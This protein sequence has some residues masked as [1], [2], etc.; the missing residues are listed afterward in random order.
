VGGDRDTLSLHREDI[1]L[2]KAVSAENKKTVVVLIGGS[3]ITMEEWKTEVPTILM[4]WYSGVEG[5]TALAK[6]LFGDVNPSGK[7]PFTIPKDPKNL[8]FFD[9]NA[10]EIEYG[11]YHGYTLFDKE[12]YVPAFPFGYGLSYTTFSYSNLE[13]EVKEDKIIAAVDVK[14][15]GNVAGDEVVQLYIGFEQSQIDRPIKLLKGFSRISLEPNEIKKVKIEVLNKNLAWYNPESK[16]WE[17]EK[18]R[19]TLYMGGSSKTEDL[20]SIQFFLKI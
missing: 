14:N 2:I 6:I 13:V 10:D 18:I 19:Y 7:L 8:P 11:Y 4:A 16:S 12:C 3:A 5:G 1:E 9:K 17:I 15:T 20:L